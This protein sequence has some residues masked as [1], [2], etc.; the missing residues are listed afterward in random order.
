MLT[1]ISQQ[2]PPGRVAFF[3]PLEIVLNPRKFERVEF[4]YRVSKNGNAGKLRDD[5]SRAFDHPKAASWIYISELDGRD[6]RLI[7]DILLHD[8]L[9]DNFLMSPYRLGLNFGTKSALDVQAVTKRKNE[10]VEEYLDRI[11]CRGRFAI[12]AKLCDRLHNI[13]TL[14]GCTEEKRMRCLAETQRYHLPLLIP[15]LRDYGGSWADYADSMDRKIKEAMS[16]R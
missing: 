12:L 4:A 2:R 7:V 9:E 6:S 14:G 11:I 13:R 3:A 1:Q 8:E 5:G 10:T 16:R 15:A